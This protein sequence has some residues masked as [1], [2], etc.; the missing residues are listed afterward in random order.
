LKA[1]DKPR[2]EPRK[3][4][5]KS[6]RL[7]RIRQGRDEAEQVGRFWVV[8]SWDTGMRSL[9]VLVYRCRPGRGDRVK[10]GPTYFHKKLTRCDERV[11]AL[12]NELALRAALEVLGLPND[13]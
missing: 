12:K 1:K 8:I 4:R 13:D 6:T 11:H 9:C 2:H 5:A 10:F 3:P 7:T